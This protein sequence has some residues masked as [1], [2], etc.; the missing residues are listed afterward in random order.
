MKK[1]SQFEKIIKERIKLGKPKIGFGLKKPNRAVIKSLIKSKKY[2]EIVLVGPNVIKNVKGFQ[3]IISQEPEKDLAT[4]LFDKKFEGIVRGTIDDFKTFEAYQ[5]LIGQEKTKEMIELGLMEDFYGRQFFISRGSNPLG[6]SK[7]EKIKDCEG[8]IK[9][10]KAELGI[11]PKIGFIT[12]VRHET[13]ERKK[14]IKEGVQK[15]L[16]Q[17]YEDANSIIDYFTKQGIEAKNYAIEIETA[18]KDGCNIVVPPNGMVGNQI[19]RTLVL[20]GGG[21]LLTGSR[22]NLLHPY[23]DNSRSETDFEPHIKWL[24]AWINGRKFRKQK[25]SI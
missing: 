11:K 9:F 14:E 15:I 24:V 1:I 5:V 18:L 23:E 21:K 4:M 22:A 6:W 7:E 10:M 3:K 12:G 16:N 2:A 13:Y 25:L 8:I 19:F 20:I 17:T